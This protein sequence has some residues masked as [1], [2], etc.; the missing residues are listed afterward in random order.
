MNSYSYPLFF[1]TLTNYFVYYVYFMSRYVTFF[2]HYFILTI[3]LKII[4]HILLKR[5]ESRVWEYIFTI[6]WRENL[7]DILSTKYYVMHGEII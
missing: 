4:D 2:F 6:N 7:V 5:I 3:V 1:S